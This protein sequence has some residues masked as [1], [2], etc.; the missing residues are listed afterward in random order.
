MLK[1]LIIIFTICICSNLSAA[2]D[3]ES[4]DKTM[5][6]IPG[7]TVNS[8][9]RVYSQTISYSFPK[10]WGVNPAYKNQKDN[11]FII[12]FLPK[13][14][15]LADW[16]D[17]FT[18]QGF[19]NLAR[20]KDLTPERMILALRQQF[21]SIAPGM[22]YYKEIYKG[23][24][25]GNSGI[26]VLMGIKE[27]P[28]DINWT[29]S[30]GVGEIGLYL[31]L[32]GKNDMYDIHRS[33][34]SAAPY[35]D[36]KLPMSQEELNKWIELLKR[37]KLHDIQTQPTDNSCENEG[38][39]VANAL[40]DSKVSEKY[41][42]CLDSGVNKLLKQFS[43]E[44]LNEIKMNQV[45]ITDSCKNEKLKYQSA[46][47]KNLVDCMNNIYPI[48]SNCR[49]N[50]E[51]KFLSKSIE[52]EKCTALVQ[53]INKTCGSGTAMDKSCFREYQAELEIVCKD[54]I[55]SARNKK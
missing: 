45:A 12:E 53:K 40:K 35:S 2:A 6:D 34:K 51:K 4:F 44:C 7:N 49:D 33:W 37:V 1:K 38:N 30:K 31:A 19:Q 47:S 26:I 9:I 22:T 32:K 3:K 36:D 10:E 17:M 28:R 5:A 41:K 23:E 39:I 46:S 11:H 8:V 24:V 52:V 18:I 16:K 25:N 50:F 21:N 29:L 15:A 43:A 14:Q 27:T 48:S 20:N 54:V 42:A 13:G 55:A